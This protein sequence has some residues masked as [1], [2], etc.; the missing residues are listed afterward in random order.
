[1]KKEIN[2]LDFGNN[3]KSFAYSGGEG[4]LRYYTLD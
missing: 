2:T 1:M 3:G 4:L